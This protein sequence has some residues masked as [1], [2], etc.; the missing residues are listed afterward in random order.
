MV[1]KFA[2][3]VVVVIPLL[4]LTVTTAFGVA[5][6]AAMVGLTWRLLP[7]PLLL[8][9]LLFTPFFVPVLNVTFFFFAAA[10]NGEDDGDGLTGLLFVGLPLVDD[11]VFGGFLTEGDDVSALPRSCTAF[12]FALTAG[13]ALCRCC[14]RRC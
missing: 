4:L 3:D 8:L 2:A 14:C 12:T 10:A 11:E 1:A 5:R 7:P 9:L 13:A 6:A